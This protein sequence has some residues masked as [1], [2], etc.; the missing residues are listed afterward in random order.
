MLWKATE[1]CTPHRNITTTKN[2]FEETLTMVSETAIQKWQMNMSDM[3][4]IQQKCTNFSPLLRS[5]IY[6][7]WTSEKRFFLF[8]TL[9]FALA[10]FPNLTQGTSTDL[11]S[12]FGNEYKIYEIWQKT[13]DGRSNSDFRSILN[14]KVKVIQFQWVERPLFLDVGKIRHACIEPPSCAYRPRWIEAVSNEYL[15]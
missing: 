3:W 15:V 13:G 2:K 1:A 10:S 7:L 5:R 12:H 6:L 14:G 8:T 9:L 11:A 4:K